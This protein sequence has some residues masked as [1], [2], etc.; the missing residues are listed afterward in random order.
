MNES[1]IFEHLAATERR[2]PALPPLEEHNPLLDEDPDAVYTVIPDTVETDL[3]TALTPQK[4]STCA[5]Y[6]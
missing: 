4:V 1:T 5:H 6:N 3:Y 2:L